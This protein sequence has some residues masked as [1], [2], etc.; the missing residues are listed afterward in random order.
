MQKLERRGVALRRVSKAGE[1]VP[2][3]RDE[4]KGFECGERVELAQAEQRVL[5]ASGEQEINQN[6]GDGEDYAD[7]A[8]GEDVEGAGDGEEAAVDS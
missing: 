4:Q 6:D 3:S 7:E 8:F 5:E 2:G 1:D